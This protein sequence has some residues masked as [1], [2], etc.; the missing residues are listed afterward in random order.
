MLVYP[1]RKIVIAIGI[2]KLVQMVILSG[3][4]VRDNGE[5]DCVVYY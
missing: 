3:P 1:E 2:V 5:G 4:Y